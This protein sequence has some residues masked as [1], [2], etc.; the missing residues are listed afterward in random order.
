[1]EKLLLIYNYSNT[2]II[3]ILYFR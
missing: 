3:I 1:M 2:T